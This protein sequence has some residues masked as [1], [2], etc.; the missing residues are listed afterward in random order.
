MQALTGMSEK[1]VENIL[2]ELFYQNVI[3]NYQVINYIAFTTA[4]IKKFVYETI[5]DKKAFHK[6]IGNKI[7]ERLSDFNKLETARHFELAGDTPAVFSLYKKK[8]K[9]LNQFPHF[10]I[11]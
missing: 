4:G 7:R 10:L 2:T 3:Q 5:Q 11:R 9:M 1:V 8:L 6:N